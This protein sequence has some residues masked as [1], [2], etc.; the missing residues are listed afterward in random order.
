[1]KKNN[2][3]GFTLIELL[4]VVA[5]IGILAAVGVTAYSG[6]TS[7]A[8]QST[9][10]AIHS[11]IYKYIAA[12]WQKCSIDSSGKVMVKDAAVAAKH[13]ACATEGA[14]AIVA[15]LVSSTNSPLEDKDPY[16]GVYAIVASAPAAK[17]VAGNVVMTSVGKVITLTTCFKLNDAGTACH[18][19]GT[20]TNT[21][22]IE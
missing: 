10:K 8:K 17:A 16:D 2:S 15:Q 4:V 12:E 3:K 22:T 20:M 18:A 19:S 6:Y 13:I 7:G 11:N 9:T 21:V 5:I 1:M 14:T